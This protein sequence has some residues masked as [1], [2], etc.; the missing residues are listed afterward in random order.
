MNSW[1]HR[2]ECKPCRA[3]DRIRTLLI[4]VAIR[5]SKGVRSL[6]DQAVECVWVRTQPSLE[7]CHNVQLL[8]VKMT[9]SNRLLCNEQVVR[10][11]SSVSVSRHTEAWKPHLQ[12]ARFGAFPQNLAS[13]RAGYLS[14]NRFLS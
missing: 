7:R 13:I 3:F 2:R 6:W 10:F 4:H 14:G 11:C 8:L 12:K 1:P 5:I 9:A